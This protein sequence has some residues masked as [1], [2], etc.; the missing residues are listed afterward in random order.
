MGNGS[1]TNSQLKFF[2]KSTSLP[3]PGISQY[4]ATCL[5][6]LS[7]FLICWRDTYLLQMLACI[8]ICSMNVHM[9]QYFSVQVFNFF[10]SALFLLFFYLSQVGGILPPNDIFKAS[11]VLL[12]QVRNQY[13]STIT[14]FVACY[15]LSFSFELFTWKLSYKWISDPFSVRIFSFNSFNLIFLNIFFTNPHVVTFLALISLR[16]LRLCCIFTVRLGK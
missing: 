14:Q 6:L 4:L 1:L 3:L 10:R 9:F 16:W 11:A 5:L 12:W 2:L 8:F 15:F 13:H 7:G